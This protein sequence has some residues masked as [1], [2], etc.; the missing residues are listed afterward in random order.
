M[1]RI[2]KKAAFV[3]KHSDLSP[4]EV[5]AV[6]TKQGLTL[7]RSYVAKLRSE[8]RGLAIAPSEPRRIGRV[9]VNPQRDSEAEFS[10]LVWRVGTLRVREWLAALDKAPTGELN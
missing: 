3:M 4:V 1:P 6:A 7:S 5:I 2:A 9:A 8:Q 10:K